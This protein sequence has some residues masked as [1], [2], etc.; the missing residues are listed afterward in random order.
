M[1]VGESLIKAENSRAKIQELRG[2]PST[3]QA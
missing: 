1:L 3:T 2:I